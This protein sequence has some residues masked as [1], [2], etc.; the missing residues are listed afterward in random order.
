MNKRYTKAFREQAMKLVTDQEY[1]VATAARQLG[2][3]PA[4]LG[5]W[6]DKAGWRRRAAVDDQGPPPGDDPVALA[7]EVLDLRRQLRQR[8][9]E[10]EILK[11]AT[12]FFAGQSLTA[13]NGSTN[14]A[15][16]SR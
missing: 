12:A 11:K 16:S 1:G 14:T 5:V 3:P 6:L 2:I 4:T 10:L 9:M 15:R 13:S 8:E 7:A